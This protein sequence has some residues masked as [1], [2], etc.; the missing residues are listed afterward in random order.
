MDFKDG[1]E[2]WEQFI[3]GPFL[4]HLRQTYKISQNREGTFCSGI[5]MG[6]MG[7]LRIGLKH[8]YLF[9]GI[10]SMEPGIE[11]ALAFSDIQVEDRFWR[12]HSLFEAAFG[13]P[14]D[15]EYWKANNPSNIVMNQADNIR[16]SNLAIYL[17]CG[18][19]DAF[20]LHRGAEFLH[21]M[22]WDHNVKHE[23][24]LVRWGE[25]IGKT[26]GPRIREALGFLTRVINPPKPDSMTR[27]LRIF[28]EAWLEDVRKKE[29]DQQQN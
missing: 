5:S 18:D 26:L 11:P 3:I 8:P 13:K 29:A 14:V 19:E 25:H 7:T 4:E 23:Y 27:D 20:N 16:E 12:D 15:E 17:E 9:A 1:S 22:L 6:G 28:N 24:H 10:A 21:R 2:K